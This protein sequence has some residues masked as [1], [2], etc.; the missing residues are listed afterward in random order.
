MVIH[1]QMTRVKRNMINIASNSEH[2]RYS[3]YTDITKAVQ[4]T[5][6]II[7]ALDLTLENNH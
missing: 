5:L 7:I 3:N 4:Y 2:P 6:L 1:A